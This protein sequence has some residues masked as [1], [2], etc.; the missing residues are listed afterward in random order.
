MTASRGDTTAFDA[1]VRQIAE[2][3]Q[4]AMTARR[5]QMRWPVLIRGVALTLLAS[6]LLGLLSWAIARL[7]A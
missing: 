1:D 7:R 6:A 2:R 3:L 5:D 4:Q